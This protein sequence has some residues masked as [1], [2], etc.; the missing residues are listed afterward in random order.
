M[1][2]TIERAAWPSFFLFPAFFFALLTSTLASYF[3]YSLGVIVILSLLCFRLPERI[4]WSWLS[5]TVVIY[6]VVI[7]GNLIFYDVAY[8][9]QDFFY[10]G[11][12]IL[13]F[14][15]CSKITLQQIFYIYRLLVYLFIILTIWAVI[16]YYTGKFYIINVGMRA[17][18][19]F[20]TPN[21][22]AA[23]LNLILFPLISINL[24]NKFSHINFY[25]MLALFYGLLLTQ[26]RGGFIS[27]IC[28]FSVLMF[29]SQFLKQKESINYKKV[30]LGLLS[31]LL[32]FITTQLYDWQNYRENKEFDLVEISRL[33]GISEHAS[34]RFILYDA[35]WQIIKEKPLLGHG[36]HNFQFYWLKDQ[37][38]PFKNSKTKFVHN[39][40]LQLL[41]DVG[42][43]GFIP[44]LLII[45]IIY[46]QS[47]SVFKKTN[48]EWGFILLGITG[49][50]TA[51]FAHAMVDFVF[52]P[53]F[54]ALLFG[55][56]I[57]TTNKVLTL[58]YNQPMFVD[59][60]K[61]YFTKYNWDL[62]FWNR[63]FSLLLMLFFIQPY[64]AE[65]CFKHAE[66]KMKSLQVEE[67]LPYYELA[68]RFVPYNEYYY[69][70][71]GTYWRTAVMHV[72]NGKLSAER[73][74]QLFADGAAANPFD[75]TNILSRAVLNRDYPQLLSY[76]ANNDTILKWFGHVLYWQ[77]DLIAGQYEYV[78]T[79]YKFGY[80][81]QA[82]KKLD[83]FLMINPESDELNELKEAHI[84]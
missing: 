64:I 31:T 24:K 21:T 63:F 67:A 3:N 4:N 79:L 76:P 58:N 77:P 73:A 36:Y 70:L 66:K 38:P 47:W 44:M 54:L 8:T 19:I 7:V 12:F 14:I 32:V 61:N 57:A 22:F 39:D 15:I 20:T 75:V 82:R 25:V 55:S 5:I 16:Q 59:K 60:L 23:A 29:F 48:K 50:M 78:K 69:G 62:F 45:I 9:Q 17:N 72:N 37:K 41:V 34:H 6:S 81:A 43:L 53:C 10:I 18:T 35:A 11:Y 71:E 49:G 30:S 13:G 46:Y 26:S 42:I 56:Y 80:N 1:M 51:F 28:G 74:D 65:L 40:Y 84:Y 2:F 27:F 83:E 52:Y 33:E 68:R